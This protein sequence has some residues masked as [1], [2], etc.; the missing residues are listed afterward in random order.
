MYTFDG[1]TCRRRSNHYCQPRADKVVAFFGEL[2]VH[3]KGRWA[4]K[5]FILSPWQEH[6]IIRPA[7]GEVIWSTEIGD[8]VRRYNVL[9]II[10]GR[11]NGKSELAAGINLFLMEGDDEAAAEIYSAA[12]D[13]KQA[14]KVWEPAKR[15]VELSPALRSRLK[16]NK[17][18]RRI[19]DEQTGS[20]YEIITSDAEGELGHNPH[21][22]NLDEVLSQADGSLWDA[23]R[24]ATGTRTQPL[25]VLTSTET[26]DPESFGADMIDELERIQED[27]KRSPHTLAFVRKMPVDADPWD[28]A[29]WFWPNPALGSFLSLDA[30]RQDALDAKND[31][32]K[33]NAFRQFRGNQRVSQ[34]SRFLQLH[35]WDA[36]SVEMFANPTWRDAELAGRMC[37]GGLD[38]SAKLDMTSWALLFDNDVVLSRYWVT[39]AAAAKLD[40]RLGGKLAVWARQGWVTITEGDV[41]DYELIYAQIEQDHADYAIAEAGFD[42]W[43]GEP[44]RQEILNR[45]GL[46]MV[47]FDSTAV[48]MTE[49][50]KELQTRL[51][52]R[53]LVHGGNPVTRWHADDLEVRR[54]RD[55]PDMMRPV[56]PERGA[57]TKRIDGI[58]TILLAIKARQVWSVQEPQGETTFLFG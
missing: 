24:T 10:V 56:K 42:R 54:Q 9:A 48:H 36:A 44:V 35:V 7:F 30:L 17:A 32:A 37:W 57:S 5:P 50:L 41:I 28:E 11:K 19:Y 58:V 2:L 16:I 18:A 6:E 45:T 47:E 26:N 21:G 39:E 53:E 29:N 51:I 3:T 46:D 1:V 20:Y 22:F 33:E 14:G 12:K 27:P 43:S 38:L 31:P 55:N 8:Y 34:K 15:M 49:P 40:K 25:M 13:T 52:D 4:R 23:M